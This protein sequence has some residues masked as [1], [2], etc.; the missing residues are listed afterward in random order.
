MEKMVLALILL[1]VHL[2]TVAARGP[3]DDE[4]ITCVEGEPLV[5]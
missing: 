1:S 5:G 4:N 2:L 3:V